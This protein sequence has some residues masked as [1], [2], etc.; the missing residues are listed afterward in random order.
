MCTNF[1]LTAHDGS[2]VVGRTMEF[3]I[4]LPWDLLVVPRGIAGRGSAPSG[5]GRSW[6][7]RYG[8]VGITVAEAH[9]GP[10]AIEAQDTVTDGVNDAGLYAGLLYLPTYADY[11]SAA[12]VEAQHLLAPIEVAS[13]VLAT[14]ATVDEAVSALADV[15][16]WAQDVA[17]IGVLPLHLSVHDRSGRAVVV[18]WVGGSQVVHDNPVGVLTNSPPFDWHLANL[19]NHV[20]LTASDLPPV[21]LAHLQIQP[22]GKGSGMLGLPGDFTPPSRFVRATAL[23]AAAYPAVDSAGALGVALHVLNSF[24][25]PK[26]VCRE[27][28]ASAPGAPSLGDYTCWSVVAECGT[29]PAYTVRTYVDPTPRRLA[30]S[31]CDLEGG[32][33]RRRSLDVAAGPASLT[34]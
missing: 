31:S 4:E 27:S 26:G 34:L 33:V 16:V 1:S 23:S 3:G 12:E 15:V 9:L 5:P 14:C 28:H 2:V 17:P 10:V 24:D 6:P 32:A 18:E 30:L 8:Y 7:G 25:I 11:P 20:N 21:E 13:Y 29:D 19:R 22:L